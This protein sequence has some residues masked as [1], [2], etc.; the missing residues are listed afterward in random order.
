MIKSNR[1]RISNKSSHLKHSQLSDRRHSGALGQSKFSRRPLMA[2]EDSKDVLRFVPLGGLEE[3]GRN[4]SFYE[5]NDEIVI[6]DAGIQF[7]EEDTPGIDYIIPN[8]EYLS[9]HKDKIKAILLTHGHYDHIAA[10]HY[11]IEK[12]GNPVIYTSA[13]T[14]EMVAKRHEEFTNVPKL[15]F[16]VVEHGTKVGLGKHFSA[17]FFNVDHIKN[18]ASPYI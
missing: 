2:R 16:Q 3:V 18:N 5:F 8:V 15:R 7:P 9:V 11:L 14:K 1:S 4:C 13:F 10:I 12:L 6:V 17:E